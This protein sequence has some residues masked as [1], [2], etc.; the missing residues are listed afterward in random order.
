MN[1][2]QCGKLLTKVVADL[3]SMP[4][5]NANLTEETL[6][7]PEK[8]FPLRV[9]VCT[10]CWLV[11]TEDFANRDE[12]FTD[13][14][15]YFS[16]F[17]SSW[18]EHSREYANR[19]IDMMG[20]NKSSTVIEAASNDGYLL[21]YFAE[22]NI[23]CYGIEPT[24]AAAALSRSK[25][26]ITV[27]DFL[28]AKTAEFISMKYGKADLVVANNVLAH[29]P[30]MNDFLQGISILLKP[31]GIATIEFQ[32]MPT[33]IDN[34]L[35]DCIYAEHYSYLSLTS[36]KNAVDRNNMHIYRVE[37]LQTHGGSIRIFIYNKDKDRVV[38]TSP[39][40]Q[41]LLDEEDKK[42][43]RTADYYRS[44][45][46]R[47]EKTKND[48]LTFLISTANANQIVA[49]YGAAA[50][51][52]TLLNF[53][54]VKKDLLPF[55]VDRNP[56]KQGKYLPGSRIPVYSEDKL[57]EEKPDYILILPWNLKDEISKQLEYT[58][59]WGCKFVTALPELE[60]F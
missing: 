31:R 42:G 21:Q 4:P 29:V 14:Y 22:R 52:N 3:G 2:R 36:V 27:D 8:W 47:I 7:R 20:L 23:P 35:W 33:M 49:A 11:Q 56:I 17:S 34:N 12:L 9:L 50:K 19:M 45:M 16:S 32:Y 60:I 55:V 30:D 26:I 40:V 13:N 53:A 5:S 18:L 24:K 43:I 15:P 1:C 54:G 48:L 10:N 44:W 25:G 41:D 46:S 57:L 59:D 58:R 37:K 28:G 39:T 38:F 51:G 6:H